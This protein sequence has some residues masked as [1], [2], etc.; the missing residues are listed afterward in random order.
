MVVSGP[1]DGLFFA[2]LEN[3]EDC[4]ERKLRDYLE[5]RIRY[6]IRNVKVR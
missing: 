5:S 6:S 4:G 3:V 1:K 2:W